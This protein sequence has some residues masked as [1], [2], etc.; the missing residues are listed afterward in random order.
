M[1]RLSEPSLFARPYPDDDGGTMI[2]ATLENAIYGLVS[3]PALYLADKHG[4]FRD[5]IDNGPTDS[6][7]LADRLGVD[8]DT[9]Q[10]LLLVLVAFGV[11]RI[12]ADGR[13]SVPTDVS[14]Y[15]DRRD[16]RYVGG[17]VE[18][19][20]VHTPTRLPRLDTFMTQGKAAADAARP[21]PFETF[22]RDEQATRAFVEAMWNL[23]YAASHELA[24]LAYL[25]DEDLLVDVGGASGP[26]A[27]AALLHRPGLRAVV[28]DLP[29]VEPYLREAGRANGVADRL[30]F[31]PGDFF[32]DELPEGDCI[33]FGYVLS[34]W[35]DQTC[36]EL[37]RKAY[38]AC[39]PG[40]R[41][42]IMERLFDDDRRGPL[43]TAVMNLEMH[44]ETQGRHRT[45]AE[46]TDLLAEAGF[47][48]ATVRRSSREKHLVI[49]HK[50]RPA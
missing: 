30:D 22:Y 6:A 47:D 13:F 3:T 38:R 7:T 34:D 21:G 18:H 32:Q 12:G 42:L 5:L 16:E 28:F 26:F 27:I 49:G 25:R 33:A 29:P 11:L 50:E 46:Y 48:T 14:P 15:L 41:V 4:I 31:A 43:A 1:N 35:T 10:R 44:V 23:S 2:P 36:L 24:R 20:I 17:F 45:G 40:G 8:Q 9:A 39:R 37:L 19:L